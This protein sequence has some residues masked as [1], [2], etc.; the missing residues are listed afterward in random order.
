MK[1][2]FGKRASLKLED[3]EKRSLTFLYGLVS[4]EESGVGGI[5]AD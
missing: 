3:G 2:C 5:G 1:N 4:K